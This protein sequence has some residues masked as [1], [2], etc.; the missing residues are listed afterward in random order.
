MSE[1]TGQILPG[2][3]FGNWLTEMAG[4]SEVIVEIGT[5]RGEGSTRCLANGLIRP[6][7]RFYTVEADPARYEEA[8]ARYSDPRIIFL[9]GTVSPMGDVPIVLDQLPA[10]IDLLLIDG[11]DDNGAKDLEALWER[12]NM[13]ALDDVN[14]HKNQANRQF[15]KMQN[16]ICRAEDLKDRNGWSIFGRPNS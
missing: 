15:L 1:P 11:G 7:Q 3:A 9:R 12:S 6:G 5:W 16:W 4:K 2:S 10:H 8:K 14:E 13:I